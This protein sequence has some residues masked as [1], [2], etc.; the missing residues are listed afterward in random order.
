M[1]YKRPGPGEMRRRELN[2]RVV[3]VGSTETRSGPFGSMFLCPSHNDVVVGFHQ[4][5][6]G[7][8]PETSKEERD[9]DLP[10]REER[11]MERTTV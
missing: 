7:F 2:L 6:S 8:L 10:T 11:T 4:E 1:T 9:S 3:P 5:R